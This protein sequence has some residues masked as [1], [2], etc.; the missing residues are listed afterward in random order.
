MVGFWEFLAWLIKYYAAPM[1]ANASPLL[2]R[3][4]LRIDKGLKF[5]DGKPLFGENKTVEGF[6]IG[7]YMGFATTLSTSMIFGE[8]SLAV[9]GFGASIAALLGDLIGAFIKRRLNIKSG[10][11]L[12]VVDQLD[13]ALAATAYYTVLGVGDVVAKPL[14][15]I[16][17]LAIIALLHVTTNNIAY[18]IGVKDK[19][20]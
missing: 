5:V 13:F 17:A 16:A 9:L 6:V 7:V 1:A 8:H 11:P 18:A 10:D 3:G 12:P 20:W 4:R 14:N 19:R 15:V 2:V